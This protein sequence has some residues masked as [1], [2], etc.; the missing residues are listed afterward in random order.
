M[1]SVELYLF[2]NANEVIN[3]ELSELEKFKFDIPID[4]FNTTN[5]E[6]SELKNSKFHIES[7]EKS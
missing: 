7:V 3:F 4:Y 5:S 2:A 6:R 1:W